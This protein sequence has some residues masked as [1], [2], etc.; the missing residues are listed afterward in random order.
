MTMDEECSMENG[1]GKELRN[2]VGFPYQWCTHPR[3]RANMTLEELL[4]L[5]LDSLNR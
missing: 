5:S 4:K 3:D 1:N 2:G